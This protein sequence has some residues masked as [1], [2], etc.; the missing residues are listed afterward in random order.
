[1]EQIPMETIEQAL[2]FLERLSP[3]QLEELR[4]EYGEKQNYFNVFF[5]ENTAF[6]STPKQKELVA[7]LAILVL[8]VFKYYGLQFP[9]YDGDYYFGFC[10]EWN[11]SFTSRGKNPTNYRRQKILIDSCRQKN[12]CQYIYDQFFL[13][14]DGKMIISQVERDMALNNLLLFVDFLDKETMKLNA[15]GLE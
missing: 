1:M 12:L 14:I 7:R 11:V 10:Q 5:F 6:S 2:D 13:T 9:N 8:F 15:Q 3:I 4:K